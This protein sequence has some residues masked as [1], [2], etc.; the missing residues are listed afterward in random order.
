MNIKI[1]MAVYQLFCKAVTPLEHFYVIIAVLTVEHISI[2]VWLK[3]LANTYTETKSSV[4]TRTWIIS[5]TEQLAHC[6]ALAVDRGHTLIPAASSV[7][8]A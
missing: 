4:W 1:F 2:L 6:L 7:L 5:P 3:S 8:L